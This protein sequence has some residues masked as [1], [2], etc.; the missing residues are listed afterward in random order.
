[1]S[2]KPHVKHHYIPQCYLRNFS[3]NGRKIYTYDKNLSKK[4]CA[5]I[6]SVC[7]INDFYKISNDYI[8]ENPEY[9]GAEL[10]IECDY[11]AQNIE[12]K[13]SELLN[14]L[15]SCKNEC[16]I[17]KCK[18]I[19]FSYK[20]KR[21][22][23]AH[24][25]IQY[26][27]L[28]HIRTETIQ[29]FDDIMPKMIELTKALAS[30]GNDNDFNDLKIVA[31]CE[32]AILHASNTFMNDEFVNKF[33]EALANNY[34]SFLVSEK[35]NF[36]TS[37]FPIVVEP[38]VPNVR[39]MYL[40][41]AQYG[42]ELTFPISKDIVITMWDREYFADKRT[43]D[44]KFYLIDEKEERRQNLLRYFNARRHVFSFYDDFQPIELCTKY[45][46]NGKHI[47]MGPNQNE[48]L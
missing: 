30:E 41:L 19:G 16:L 33:S 36:Y 22:I 40:G 4:Y 24:I 38:H 3:N 32:P 10:M 9:E 13:Y 46:N 37:D 47:F 14:R 25:V 23:A 20:D 26:L 48:V 44:C 34:W 39:P 31:H 29:L 43:E 45:L 1:M 21:I 12:P 5:D 17:D 35:G 27:R 18:N 6:S 8:E 7:E 11:F 28:P 2:K 42:S 15:I